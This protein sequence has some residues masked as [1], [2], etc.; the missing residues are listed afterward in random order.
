MH[1]CIC[2]YV[3]TYISE[4]HEV[5]PPIYFHRNCNR[6]SEHIKNVS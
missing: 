1:V 5:M 2:M 3:Y 6:Y 4:L